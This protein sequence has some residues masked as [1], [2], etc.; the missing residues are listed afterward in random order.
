MYSIDP[1]EE[2]NKEKYIGICNVSSEE[3]EERYREV[4]N[5]LGKYGKR[6]KVV[7]MFSQGAAKGFTQDSLDFIYIDANHSYTACKEDLELWWPKLR[8][9]GI[10]A[11]H[12][13]LDGKLPEG[14][15]GVKSAVNEFAEKYKQE[16]FV[17]SEAWPTWYLIKR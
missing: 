12:D 13:Y 16:V 5:K 14:E 17:T 10:F 11:G 4:V 15:F 2:L 9:G 7:R 3:Q 8:K 1:W 6:S